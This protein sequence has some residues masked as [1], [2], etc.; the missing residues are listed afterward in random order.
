LQNMRIRA[1]VQKQIMVMLVDSGS[2][3]TFISEH[4]VQKLALPTHSC[5]PV[6][7]KVANGASINRHQMV[8]MWNGGQMVTSIILI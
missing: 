6:T 7:V 5:S 3:T 1:V 8:K 2:S 4:M